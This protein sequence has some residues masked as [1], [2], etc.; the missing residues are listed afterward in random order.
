M[1]CAFGYLSPMVQK[2]FTGSKLL[3][4]KVDKSLINRNADHFTAVK[5]ALDVIQE[6]RREG[7]LDDKFLPQIVAEIN[8]LQ[9]VCDQLIGFKYA[10]FGKPLT[11]VVMFYICSYFTTS[12]V[13]I[14]H[15]VL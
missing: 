14:L 2:R 8:A 5:L 15:T 9:S 7:E 3:T 13:R 11:F 6:V 10:V 4:D 12:S 1:T